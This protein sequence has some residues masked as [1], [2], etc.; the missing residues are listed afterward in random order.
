MGTFILGAGFSRPADLPLGNDLFPEIISLAKEQGLFHLL[1]DDIEHYCNYFRRTR[2]KNLKEKDINFEEF[3]SY[4][5]IEHYLTLEGSDHFSGEGN[6][7]QLIVKNC[8]ALLLFL[9]EQVVTEIQWSLY[10]D[11]V[12]RLEPNDWIFTFNY[13]TILEK[14]FEKKNTPYRLFPTRYERDGSGIV[15]NEKDEIVLLKMH[16]SINWFDSTY[17]KE[18][19]RRLREQF[20]NDVQP[21]NIIFKHP[22]V[23]KAKKLV[24]SPGYEDSPLKNI[25]I[26]ENLGKY[27]QES[28]F[29]L[30]VPLIISPSYNKLVYLNPLKEF[31]WGFNQM[32]SF[33]KRVA[34]IGFSLPEHDEYIRQPLYHLIRNFQYYKGIEKHNLKMIDLQESLEGVEGYKKK[35]QFVN[36]D[37]TDFYFDGFD[38]RALDIIFDDKHDED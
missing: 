37:K 24:D 9:R 20:G 22:D 13:D 3:I 15:D 6:R 26:V 16:G 12:G 28:G 8:I 27:F 7:S 10:E 1:E 29:I 5:D 34:V 21:Y 31:W 30:E 23:Y 11:F 4:L 2:G 32:G 14:V 17:S 35:Y 25:Y 19:T 18:S 33:E 36:F 38:Q